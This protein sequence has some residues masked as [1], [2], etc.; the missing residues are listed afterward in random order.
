MCLTALECK[1]Y[2]VNAIINNF[3]PVFT[4]IVNRLIFYDLNL[5][6]VVRSN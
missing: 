6:I 5:N 2:F 4:N 1:A 3:K